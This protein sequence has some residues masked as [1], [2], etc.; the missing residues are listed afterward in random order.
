M[1]GQVNYLIYIIGGGCFQVTRFFYKQRQTEIGKKKAN[2]KQHPEAELLLFEVIHIL[3]P[4]YH[5]K[6]IR[7]ILKNK[8]KNKCV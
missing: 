8:Q 3:H 6:I 2:A 7:Y 4:R 1:V 5:A